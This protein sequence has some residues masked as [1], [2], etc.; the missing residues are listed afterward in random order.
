V[1][2][3][4]KSP[5]DFSALRTIPLAAR[6]GK[7]KVSDFAVP[8]CAGSGIPGWLDSLPRILAGDSFR[9]VVE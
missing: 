3:Y 1:S 5:L 8:Y 6:G 7:V 9:A 4:P 2:H